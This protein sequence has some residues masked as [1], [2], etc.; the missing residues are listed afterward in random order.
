MVGVK[1]PSPLP[2][3]SVKLKSGSFMTIKS[4][5]PS[6]FRSAVAIALGLW[7]VVGWVGDMEK[8]PSPLPSSMVTLP[9]NWAGAGKQETAGPE[10]QVF[11]TARSILPSP[12]KSAATNCVGYAPGSEMVFPGRNVPSPF[13]SNMVIVLS[14]EFTTAKPSCPVPKKSTAAIAEGLFPVV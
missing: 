4:R 5:M 8:V 6:P 2:I 3:S 12:L 13:G 7:P 11:R 14:P 1:V 9:G 10:P